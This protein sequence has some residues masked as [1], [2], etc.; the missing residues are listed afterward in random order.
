MNHG[1]QLTPIEQ[2][3]SETPGTHHQAPSSINT[4]GA[5]SVII[6]IAVKQIKFSNGR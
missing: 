5:T 4:E 2:D 6:I 1:L 3:P